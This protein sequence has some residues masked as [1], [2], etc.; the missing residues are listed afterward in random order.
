[1][2]NKKKKTW[3]KSVE[4]DGLTETIRVE[5]VENG[6][7]ISKEKYGHDLKSTSKDKY[8]S[9]NKKYISTKNPL[10]NDVDGDFEDALKQFK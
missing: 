2:A 10:D 9:E 4:R 5:Q 6:F 1:M 8:I 7:I 3:S